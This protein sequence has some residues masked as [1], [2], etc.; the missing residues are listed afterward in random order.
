MQ[1]SAY[2]ILRRDALGQA[3][4]IE[5]AP[6]LDAAKARVLHLAERFPAEYVIFHQAS[7]SVVADFHFKPTPAQPDDAK[8]IPASTVGR[9]LLIDDGDSVRE[10]LRTFLERRG[11][12]VCG[13]ATDGIDAIEKAKVL[14]PD[15]IILDLAMPRMNGMEAASILSGIM[16]GVPIVLLTIYGDFMGSALAAASGIKAVISK[17]DSLDKLASCVQ[18][19]LQKSQRLTTGIGVQQ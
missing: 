18:S 15:L 12:Q 4:W 6:D 16:P 13:E 14:K 5:A 17:T 1:T 3:T 9:L 2:D 10:V 11:F 8:L 7:A 19:L